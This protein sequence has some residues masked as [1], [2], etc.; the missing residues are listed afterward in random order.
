[1]FTIRG[2]FITKMRDGDMPHRRQIGSIEGARIRTALGAAEE[3]RGNV[4]L[5]DY[6]KQFFYIKTPDHVYKIPRMA[7]LLC[8][9]FH[10]LFTGGRIVR[11]ETHNV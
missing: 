8:S 9:N 4:Y 3:G 10:T 7:V 1:V 11:Q 5:I 2:E 6:D